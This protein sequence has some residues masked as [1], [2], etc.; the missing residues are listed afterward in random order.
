MVKCPRGCG[1]FLEF[2]TDQLGRTVER[3]PR[4]GATGMTVQSPHH[5]RDAAGAG[6]PATTRSITSIEYSHAT[7]KRRLD[8]ELQTQRREF[9]A[10]GPNAKYC[11]ACPQCLEVA[12]DALE[13]TTR[14]PKA[15][16]PEKKR[17]RIETGHR[18]ASPR[19]TRS[20]SGIDL[21]GAIA[22]I[23]EQVAALD[24][25]RERLLGAIE[26]LRELEA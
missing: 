17:K 18:P 24:A 11:G 21:S 6:A 13:P 16:K 22:K 26:S 14:K 1:V 20:A 25:Q 12:A 5:L 23:E 2:G 19:S 9:K 7:T 15:D 4:C 3:C 10:N 8:Q